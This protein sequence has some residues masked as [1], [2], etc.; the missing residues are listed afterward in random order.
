MIKIQTAIAYVVAHWGTVLFY[1]GVAISVL[2]T[3][4]SVVDRFTGKTAKDIDG[5]LGKLLDVF[6][7]ITQ[8]GAHGPLALLPEWLLAFIPE[9][10]RSL[11]TAVTVP[12]LVSKPVAV[13]AI[14][15]PGGVKG[16]SVLLPFVLFAFTGCAGGKVFG[17]CELALLPQTAQSLVAAVAGLASQSEGYV[18]ALIQ[19]GKEIGPGQIACVAQAIAADQQAKAKTPA[20]VAHLGEYLATAH[21]LGIKAACR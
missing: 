15:D 18:E 21:K 3:V 6:T 10:L 20:M 9:P 14:G 1:T 8:K 16:A 5:A 4:K 11:I 13:G 17:R 19:L 12:G 7:V 2:G